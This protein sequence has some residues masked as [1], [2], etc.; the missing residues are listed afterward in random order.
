MIL[1]SPWGKATTLGP[2]PK[3]YPWWTQVVYQLKSL[4]Y[5]VHQ[6]SCKG[7]SDVAGCDRRSD[8]LP[9]AEL[10]GLLRECHTFIS[11]DSM[12]QHLAW[13]IGEPGVVIFG[14]SDPEIFGHSLHINLLKSRRYLREQQFWLWS[15]VQAKPDAFVSPNEIVA[16]ALLSITRR[17][18]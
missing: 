5:Q 2:S 18:R 4:N 15:Q 3:N 11:V 1:I 9:L 13:S 14:L 12:L 10:E 8:N 7:E 6:V 17:K 16:A